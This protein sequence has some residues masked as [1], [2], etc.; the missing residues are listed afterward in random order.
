MPVGLLR[1]D[2]DQLELAA[3][4]IVKEADP[5]VQDCGL[6]DIVP[7]DRKNVAHQHVLQV[8]GFAGG[9]AHGQDGG[10]R[11]RPQPASDPRKSRQNCSIARTA[12]WIATEV[13]S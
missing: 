1:I 6:D 8:L 7:R 3:E 10:G 2:R 13:R 4:D 11:G 9:F 5:A 12:A